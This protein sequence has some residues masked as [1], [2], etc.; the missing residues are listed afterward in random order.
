MQLPRA[1][2]NV[3][4][5][6]VVERIAQQAA[7]SAEPLDDDEQYFLDNL[8][9]EPTNPTAT[10]GFNTAYEASWP[11]P[12]LR[13]FRFE[14]LC[15]LAKDAHSRDI[16]ARPDA[17]REWEFASAVLEFHRHPMSWLLGWAGIRAGKRPARWD[18]LLLVATATFVVV[19]FLVGVLALSIVTD[20]QKEVWKW[21][22]WVVGACVYSTII[23]LLY[24]A[25]KRLEAR[26]RERNIELCRCDLPVHDSAHT[27]LK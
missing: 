26:Q 20:G 5:T 4:L 24:F 17:A 16:Q 2:L 22:L 9:T 12:V 23:T 15:K 13:D 25:V 6:F 11:E 1:D 21:T 10:W 19:L 8:P 14:R 7:H 27:S 18:L 3:A